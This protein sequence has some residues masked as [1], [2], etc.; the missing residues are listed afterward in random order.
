MYQMLVKQYIYLFLLKVNCLKYIK[1]KSIVMYN[2]AIRL[3]I[4]K[5]KIFFLDLIKKNIDYFPDEQCKF[6]SI[7]NCY[8][9]LEWFSTNNCDCLGKFH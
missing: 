8:K 9:S 1:I 4:K 3:T 7:N 2:L 5:E 6:S